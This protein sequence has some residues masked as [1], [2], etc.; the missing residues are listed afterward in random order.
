MQISK[1]EPFHHLLPELS[2]DIKMIL[3]SH[4]W[5]EASDD[6]IMN[7]EKA[8]CLIK[9]QLVCKAFYDLFGHNEFWQKNGRTCDTSPW[10]N[11]KQKY[12][13]KILK[14]D[15]QT[16]TQ[17]RD[18]R[19]NFSIAIAKKKSNIKNERRYISPEEIEKLAGVIHHK[20]KQIHSAKHH[21][22]EIEP[23]P[24]NKARN[25]DRQTFPKTD[26]RHLL[27]HELQ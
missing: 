13:A 23:L 4:L 20:G 16:R 19:E 15:T 11:A 14:I 5:E 12:K 18:L 17:N 26:C 3:A 9:L 21:C 1:Y 25:P 2:S 27:L 6:F 22:L 8:R 24:C 10:E 7:M